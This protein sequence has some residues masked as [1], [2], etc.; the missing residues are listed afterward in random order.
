MGEGCFNC[1]F[2]YLWRMYVSGVTAELLL[3]GV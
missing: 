2:T 3:E 1:V